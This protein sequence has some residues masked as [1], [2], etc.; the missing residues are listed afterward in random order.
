[1]DG[2]CLLQDRLWDWEVVVVVVV[3]EEEVVTT[4]RRRVKERDEMP[5]WR[6]LI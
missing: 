2:N 1:M 5:N 4:P 6:V 3:A